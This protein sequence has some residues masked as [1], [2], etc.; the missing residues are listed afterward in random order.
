MSDRSTY[1]PHAKVFVA[2][3]AEQLNEKTGDY[4]S[5]L[6]GSGVD[7]EMIH[8]SDPSISSVDRGYVICHTVHYYTN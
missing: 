7:P 6:I 2:F 4:I 8:V 3:T 5:T 1:I